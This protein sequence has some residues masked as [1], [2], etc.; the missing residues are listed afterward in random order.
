L[1]LFHVTSA[2]KVSDILHV[3]IR[4]GK[5]PIWFKKGKGLFPQG[6]I[7]AFTDYRD[8]AQ[9][10][11]TQSRH[12]SKSTVIITFTADPTHWIADEH[13]EHA[14]ERLGKWIKSDRTVLPKAILEIACQAQWI[15][16]ID[17]AITNLPLSGEMNV[18]QRFQ[19]HLSAISQFFVLTDGENGKER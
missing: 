16:Q 9:W 2:S 17:P 1:N 4:T 10:A 8:A 5:S 7:F 15:I 3:G 6:F 19:T 14:L 11:L 18:W 13:P 12:T